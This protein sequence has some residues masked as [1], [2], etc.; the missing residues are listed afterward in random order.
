ML[1]QLRKDTLN[2]LEE[3]SYFLI[4]MKQTVNDWKL[5]KFNLSAFLSAARSITLVMQ[6]EYAPASGFERWYMLPQV[7]ME[8][9]KLLTF[10]KELRN[11]SIH[12]KQVNPRFQFS[13][14]VADLFAMPSGSTIVMGDKKE[15]TYLTNASVAEVAAS[16]A[17]KIRAIQKWYFDEKP[18][19]DVITLCERYLSSMSMLVYDC[20]EKFDTVAPN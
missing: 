14:T 20:G 4:Q 2:K 12:Q 19:E 10:F 1:T 9:D 16:D 7:E 13:F 8:K 15:G 5:F 17:T 6:K 11:T 18:D 3:C